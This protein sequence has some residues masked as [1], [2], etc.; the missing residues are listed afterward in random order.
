MWHLDQYTNQFNKKPELI[1]QANS[2]QCLV[3]HN[4]YKPCW[5]SRRLT[6]CD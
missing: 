1:I 6:Y 4:L 2:S 5:P 3:F